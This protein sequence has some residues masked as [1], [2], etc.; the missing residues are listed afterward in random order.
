MKKGMIIVA[1]IVLAAIAASPATAAHRE[2]QGGYGSGPGNVTDIAG[3]PGLNLSAEQTERIGALREAHRRDIKPLQEQLM[4]KGRQLR[5]LWLAKTPDRERILALQR[6]VHDL[7]GR[8]LEKLAAYRLEVLQ[9]LTPDQQAKVQTFEAERHMGRMGA[10]GM[11]RGPSPG[12]H[13]GGHPPMGD[14]FREKRPGP[15]PKAGGRARRGGEPSVLRTGEGTASETEG[16][17]QTT[18]EPSPG[19]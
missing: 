2:W 13:E 15:L 3:I 9:M 17:L 14:P 4:G 19:D 18:D 1:V 8:L 11:D 7:R 5:E 6:E 12:W 10:A 16:V